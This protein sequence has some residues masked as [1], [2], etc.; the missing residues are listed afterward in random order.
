MKKKIV[1][2]VAALLIA[3]SAMPMNM[4]AEVFPS[5]GSVLI[6]ASA[7]SDIDVGDK[8][9]R[10][11]ENYTNSESVKEKRVEVYTTFSD[12]TVS[13][14]TIG[15]SDAEYNEIA[16]AVNES[17]DISEFKIAFMGNWNTETGKAENMR[18]FSALAKVS[19]NNDHLDT[20]GDN[21]FNGCAKL[22]TVSLSSNI[23]YI[24][25]NAF[26][27]CTLFVGGDNNHLDLSNVYEIDNYAFSGA[28]FTSVTLGNQLTRIGE[29]AFSSCQN[30]T[31]VE[32][33]SSIYRLRNKAF[34]NCTSLNSVVFAEGCEPQIIGGG[35]FANCS[36]L[37][38]VTVKGVT[39]DAG[40][41]NTLPADK[42]GV[43]GE[44]IFE[45]CTSLQSFLWP[46]Q[47]TFLPERTF[48][49]CTKLNKVYFGDKNANS[50]VIGFIGNSAF[51]NCTNLTDIVLPESAKIIAGG[52]F[53]NCEKLKSVVVSDTLEY[54]SGHKETEP[55][56]V[57]QYGPGVYM[58]RIEQKLNNNYTTYGDRWEH[59]DGSTF[60][61]CKQLSIYPRSKMSDAASNP[62]AYKNKILLPDTLVAVPTNCFEGCSGITSVKIPSVKS[63]GANAFKN[64]IALVSAN[65]PDYTV[66]APD[67]GYTFINDSTFYNCTAL[68]DVEI[69]NNVRYFRDS[70]FESCS[71]LET[72]TISGK[73]KINKTVQIPDTTT[74]IMRKAFLKCTAF[75]YL[76]FGSGSELGALGESAFENCSSLKG[77]NTGS[78]ANDTISVPSGIKVIEK[79]V[80]AKDESLEK[81]TF[82]GD[83]Q[84]VGESAFDSCSNLTQVTMNDT[85]ETVYNS[86]FA[87]CTSLKKMPQTTD[88]KP[89]LVNLKVI[90]P[91]TFYN[92]TSLESAYISKNITQINDSAFQKCKNLKNVQWEEGSALWGIGNTAFAECES[93]EL[94]SPKT[95]GTQST[96]PATLESIGRSTFEKSGLKEVKI[97]KPSS[98]ELLFIGDNAFANSPAL[99]K[100]DLSDSLI[101]SIPNYLCSGC[102]ALK[103]VILP[104]GSVYTIGDRSFYNCYYLHTFGE[105]GSKDGEY[106][107]P[108]GL[109]KIGSGAFENNYCMQKIT[110][111]SSVSQ[112]DLSMFNIKF[113]I[114]EIEEKGYTPIEEINVSP[115]NE[116]YAA[117]NGILYNKAKTT[118]LC[119]PLNKQGAEFS[120]PNNVEVI[121]ECAM[122]A[123]FNLTDVK[124]NE[125]LKEIQEKAFKDDY[126]LKNVDFG[127]NS[128]VVIS[129]NA[130][131]GHKDKPT[132]YGTAGSTAD[133]LAQTNTN[134]IFVDNAKAAA[135]IKLLNEAGAVITGDTF[136]VSLMKNRYQFGV[137]Q[138]TKK[139]EVSLD[140]LKWDVDK[141]D[142]AT[143]NNM[144]QLIFKQQGS[145]TMTVQNAAGTA[146][147]KVKVVI[148]D[149]EVLDEY[150]KGDVDGSSVID[151]EDAVKIIAHING[152]SALNGSSEKA[153]DVDGNGSIDIEDAVA[154]I[155]HVNGISPID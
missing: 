22:T 83:I 153:A 38:S 46:A 39:L 56:P 119:Y 15:L 90:N 132:L 79:R 109:N 111:P 53:T 127:K 129:S 91:S 108:E 4:I 92:C 102:S 88:G 20:I 66:K 7:L 23:R 49:G 99:T 115:D 48:S 37:S 36:K 80:F 71:S 96:F 17:G 75:D 130:F 143:V 137:I 10:F 12:H 13:N 44:G 110:F 32:I 29:Q 70:C 73:S 6:T 28:K 42:L 16:A 63:V 144:G 154:V 59:L 87:N 74:S 62:N 106:V 145:V 58:I 139:G 86:A 1:A 67:N 95:S 94:I 72:V 19:F 114:N 141:S 61:G 84:Y 117:E 8:H 123:N 45:N 97:D 76:N 21:A 93:L 105:K 147:R 77:S 133:K 118:L 26:S 68:K 135:V 140:T 33:P 103:T 43:Y 113:R 78:S 101:S 11:N 112:I 138:E 47:S 40:T 69:P 149:G 89:A 136:K 155:G 55:A 125:G 51:Y 134:V 124:I 31:A 30:L 25:R 116:A 5:V 100:L 81:I 128:S 18:D 142:V 120:I 24:G 52:A 148:I 107:L 82:L 27:N 151:I 122:A 152:V 65:I 126:N 104:K 34:Y 60:G 14:L 64:C 41:D 146:V 35:A 85:I 50:S 2:S 121:S 98:G 54:I 131:A 150:K 57:A 3:A 9:I